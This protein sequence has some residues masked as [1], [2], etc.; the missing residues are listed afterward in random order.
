MYFKNFPKFIYDFKYDSTDD[1]KTSVVMDVTRNIRFR[2]DLLANVTVYDEY[3]IQDGDTPEIVAERIYG[4]PEYHWIIMLANE[5][6][7][8]LNDYPLQERDLIKYIADEHNPTLTS[9]AWSYNGNTITVTVPLHGLQVSP[10][11]SV[12]ITGAVAGT[13][14]PNGTYNVASVVD[15]NRFRYTVSSTPTGTASGTLTINTKNRESY[16]RHYV[17]AEGFVVNSNATGAVAVTHEQA[18][19]DENETKRRI[20]IISPKLLSVILKNYKD[21]M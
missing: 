7:D 20:K 1:T 15:A 5:R 3:D 2:R 12:T 21:L 18:E 4:N 9:T 8:Y 13:N 17:N 14:A 16:I 11:T 6:Y 10:T 19:R